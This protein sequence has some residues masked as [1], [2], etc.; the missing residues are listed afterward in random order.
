MLKLLFQLDEAGKGNFRFA[1][2]SESWT[3]RLGV[4]KNYDRDIFDAWPQPAALAALVPQMSGAGIEYTSTLE[5]EDRSCF[6]PGIKKNS[7]RYTRWK[8]KARHCVKARRDGTSTF[9]TCTVIYYLLILDPYICY[10]QKNMKLK[11]YFFYYSLPKSSFESYTAFNCCYFFKLWNACDTYRTLNCKPSLVQGIQL[12]IRGAKYPWCSTATTML[13]TK[14]VHS[15]WTLLI[16]TRESLLSQVH[17][18][19]WQSELVL[20][21]LTVL[22]AHVSKY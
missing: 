15:L 14:W 20:F 12:Y 8:L 16:W 3:F 18:C 5:K 11:I 22:L 17:Q 7:I 10:I 19:S 1:H 2:R 4:L 13:L 6:R 21:L 9:V